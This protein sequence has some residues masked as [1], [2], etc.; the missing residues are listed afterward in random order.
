MDTTHL[1]NFTPYLDFFFPA[2]MA[3]ESS[4]ARSRTCSMGVTQATAM[5]PP[6]P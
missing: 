6:D 2:P 1:A 4:W 3:S 5:T